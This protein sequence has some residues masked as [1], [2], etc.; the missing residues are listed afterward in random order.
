MVGS[1]V[2]VLERES[3]IGPASVGIGQIPDR[4]PGSFS[5]ISNQTRVAFDEKPIRS[6]G[7]AMRNSAHSTIDREN[8]SPRDRVMDENRLFENFVC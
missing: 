7:V 4:I 2:N 8:A 5:R 3:E 1:E 6:T